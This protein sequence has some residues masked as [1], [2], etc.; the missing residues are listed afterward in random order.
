MK[1]FMFALMAA[2]LLPAAI[3]LT[4]CGDGQFSKA[5]LNT[6]GNYEEK[7]V[8]DVTTIINADTST[9][10]GYRVSF[11]ATMT[12]GSTTNEMNAV[13]LFKMYDGVDNVDTTDIALKMTSKSDGKTGEMEMFGRSTDTEENYYVKTVADGKTEKVKY[14]DSSAMSA[15]G[16]YINMVEKYYPNTDTLNNVDKIE[17]ATSG[18][19]KKI[20]LTTNLS[21]DDK[22][23]V[24]YVYE[25]GAFAGMKIENVKI[26]MGSAGAIRFNATMTTFDG[27]INFPN[28]DD[29]TDA[30]Q[31]A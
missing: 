18:T 10:A 20:K 30:S 4:G 16:S 19:T 31:K 12:S 2:V 13:M 15:I 3:V 11:D 29:Y 21:A 5:N 17:I 8:A 24:Y 23:V 25:D 6:S 27:N 1:K 28:A 14:T 7:T 9:L 26:D 22:S